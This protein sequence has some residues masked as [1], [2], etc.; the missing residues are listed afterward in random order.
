M[1]TFFVLLFFATVALMVFEY[2]VFWAWSKSYVTN[3]TVVWRQGDPHL[4]MIRCIL[5]YFVAVFAIAARTIG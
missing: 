4:F 5:Y 1:F 3:N 2:V